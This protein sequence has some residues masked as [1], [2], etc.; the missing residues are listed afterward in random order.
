MQLIYID[1]N[2]FGYLLLPHP[3]TNDPYVKQA[4]NFILD[5]EN[6]KYTGITSTLTEVEYMDVAKKLISKKNNNQISLHEEQIAMNNL[7]RFIQRLG[8][9][10]VDADQITSELFGEPRIFGS[11][12]DIVRCPSLFM[13]AITG[14]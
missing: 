8:I 4:N 9:G 1:A 2:V 10:L 3:Q 5:I 7:I 14:K 11:A 12:G 13:R 6:G